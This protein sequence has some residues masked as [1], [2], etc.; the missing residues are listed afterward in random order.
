MI[1]P[2]AI[3]EKGAKIDDTVEVGAYAIISGAARIGSGCRIGA[4]AQLYGRLEIGPESS[5][6]PA[7]I[8]GGDPQDLTFDNTLESGVRIGSGNDLREQV[9]VHRSTVGGGWTEIGNDNC[10]MAGSHVGHDVTIGNRNVIANNCLLA[11][12]VRIANN[13]FL[14]GG[15]AFH[16]FVHVGEL[17]ITQGNSAISKDIPPY[18]IA[19]QLNNLSGLNVVGMRRA[20]IDPETRSE[21]KRAYRAA[22]LSDM[23]LGLALDKIQQQQW[24]EAAC[25][26]I[27]ALAN[28]SRKGTC[29]P[30]SRRK[31]RK[32]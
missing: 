8:I 9:T 17:S 5:I 2:T 22:F 14:G 11:G 20:G 12:Y 10:L 24:G 23:P 1:H 18:C 28:P 15:A 26:F 27:D 19:S 29:F 4:H 3:I 6:G 25:H 16:Q 31:T 30:R 13:A 21:I 32:P 7:A